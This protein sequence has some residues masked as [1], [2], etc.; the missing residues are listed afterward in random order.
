MFGL[1]WGEILIILGVGVFVLGPERIPVAVRWVSEA[2][3]K[4][5]TMAAGAQEDLKREI[6][7]ELEELRRQVA[8]LQSLKEYQDLKSLRDMN[9]KKILQK[10]ILGDQF[11]GGITGFLGLKDTKA[12]GDT[13][14]A[15]AAAAGSPGGN[16]VPISTEKP[17]LLD[18]NMPVRRVTAPLSKGDIPPFD[19]EGT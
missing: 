12:P 6:G 13:A 7:P 16:W 8:D 18:M 17:A 15:A 4:L 2:S 9:P 3:K 14:N 11:S 19:I 1:G 5:K 10:N